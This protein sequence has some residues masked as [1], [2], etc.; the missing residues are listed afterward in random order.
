MSVGHAMT[1]GVPVR[2]EQDFPGFKMEGYR[3]SGINQVMVVHQ[4]CFRL[5]QYA[6]Q[7]NWT[8]KVMASYTDHADVA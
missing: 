3:S 2:L 1:F 4:V 5:N 7:L 8:D 6:V